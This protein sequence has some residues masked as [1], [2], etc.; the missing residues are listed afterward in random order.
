[1]RAALLFPHFVGVRIART[2][3]SPDELTIEA[4]PRAA[5]AR[6][7]DCRQRSR[8]VHSRYTR[9]IADRPVGE[10]R[11]TIHL[12]VRRF[13]CRTAQCPRRTFAE[14]APQLA[15]RYAR[16]SRPLQGRLQDLGLTLG[17]HPGMRFARRAGMRIS[18]TTLLRR[19]RASPEP[20]ITAPRV[21]GVDDFALRRGHHYGTVLTDLE[22]RCVVDVLPDRTA[23]SFATWLK[24]HG[25]PQL[26]CRDRGGDYASG[27]RQGAPAAV[28]IADRFHLAR[29]SSDALER[30]LA[31]H[32]AALRAAVT[33]A[34]PPAAADGPAPPPAAVA[35]HDPRRERRLARYERVVALR[36]EGCSITAIGREVG[37]CRETV[38]RYLHA[39]GFPERPGRRT[40][41]SAGTARG[42]F[43]Q[44][45]WNA[46]CRDA[47][48]LW[49]ALRDCG[50][51]GSLRMVQRVVSGWRVEPGRRGRA[52]KR[53]GAVSA[54]APARPRPPSARQAVWLLLRPIET[55]EPAQLKM[56]ERLLAAA[57]EVGGA[58]PVLEDFRRMVRERDHAALAGWLQAAEASMARELRAFAA[59]LRRDLAAVEAALTYEWSS[60][61]VEG[62]VT[63]IK[64]VKRQMFDSVGEL[65]RLR[66]FKKCRERRLG[67]SSLNR[68]REPIHGAQKITGSSDMQLLL[69]GSR[70]SAIAR[71]P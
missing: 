28:Q 31:R 52:A 16:H 15:A 26:I 65:Q 30:L 39:G 1:M 5:T 64:L 62:Q 8:H 53:A 67:W 36:Q 43:L 48:V 66:C 20:P 25:Q 44:A 19:V 56:R 7:P 59:N 38:R 60:G 17:G 71:A 45:R 32:P 33:E 14:Q 55:L 37:L 12:R 35:S 29:N 69:V 58:L 24:Q 21:L 41:R 11:V 2:E 3:V 18:R 54:S 27:A 51:T 23:A 61:Q 40:K 50:F 49:A 42:A 6:C 9:S 22:R 70:E 47:T 46:G 57:P 13:R 68:R 63:K 10:R 4:R 34:T